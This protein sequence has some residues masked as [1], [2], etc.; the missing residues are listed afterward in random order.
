MQIKTILIL[1]ILFWAFN[2]RGQTLEEAE[3]ALKG[4][5]KIEDID[6]LKNEHPDWYI[7]IDKTILSD[8][9][10]FPDIA[11]AEIG[12]IVL[13]QYD[14]DAPK[15]I[16]KVLKVEEEELCR[17]KHIYLN[18]ANYTRSEIDSLRTLIINRFN[19]GEDFE[20]LVKEYSM[21][22]NPIG[23]LGWFYKGK[24]VDEFDNAV[25]PRKK[26]EIFTVDV[27]DNDWYYVILKTHDNIIEK[28]IKSIMIKY[29]T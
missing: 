18:G 4:A 27:E 15:F 5:E 24:M 25:R 29:G 9:Q 19:N 20:L 21:Y 7:S 26:G 1:P 16:M 13:K 3:K 14:A 28:V 11:K 8:S 23:D 6:N 10:V 2:L 17:V 22:R 12:E